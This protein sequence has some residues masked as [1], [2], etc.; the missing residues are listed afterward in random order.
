MFLKKAI[1]LPRLDER[2]QAFFLCLYKDAASLL[3]MD[4]ASVSQLNLQDCLKKAIYLPRLD[5]RIQA[6]FLCLYK[7]AASLLDMD[8]ASVLQLNLQDCLLV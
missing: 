8:E 2:I 3:D 1:Y 4:E 7:D 5:E 6:F